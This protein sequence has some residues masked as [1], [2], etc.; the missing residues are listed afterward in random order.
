MLES[1]ATPLKTYNV[2]DVPVARATM[3][4]AI[5]Q[6][7]DWVQHTDVP[8][9]VCFTNVHMVVEANTRPAFRSVMSRMDLNFPDGAP[10]FWL[11][12]RR[13][14]ARVEKVS[15][16]EF[17]PAFCEQSVELGH[18]HYLFGG[19]PG[20]AEATGKAL[21]A[22]YPGLQIAGHECPPFGRQ[23][24]EESSDMVARI[25]ASGADLLWVCLGCPKQEQWMTDHRHLL[26][27][28]VVL[29]VGQAFDVLAGRTKRAPAILSKWGFEWAFRLVCEPRRLYKRYMVTN[30]LFLWLL[31]RER[32]IS[33]GTVSI[34]PTAASRH[35]RIG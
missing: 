33:Q 5:A 8:R 12:R 9:L 1:T 4:E 27:V 31:L 21:E 32:F 7:N 28:K 3:P 30:S 19:M 10:I 26:N 18:K 22:A 20:V 35:T 11:G 24:P 13:H 14:G 16:P 15:G 2:L 29:A 25:N 6:V 17:M 34:A 23:S